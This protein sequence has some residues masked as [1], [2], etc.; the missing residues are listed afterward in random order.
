[1]PIGLVE[2]GDQQVLRMGVSAEYAISPMFSVFGGIDYL[3]TSYAGGYT[4]DAP[5]VSVSDQNSDI[6]NA[7]I[8]LSVKFNEYLTGTASY[9][10]TDSSSDLLGAHL[11]PQPDQRGLERGV[12]I[13]PPAL[14]HKPLSEPLFA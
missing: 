1:M 14:N 13:G 6:F 12:L 8:G 11:R 5:H 2:F 7:Y 10:Y 4:V 3:P 9:N